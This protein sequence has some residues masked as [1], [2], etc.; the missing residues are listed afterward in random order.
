M[1]R[2][3]EDSIVRRGGLGGSRYILDRVISANLLL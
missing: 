1:E 2:G 3:I